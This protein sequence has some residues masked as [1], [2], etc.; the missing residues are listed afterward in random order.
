MRFLANERCELLPPV[1]PRPICCWRNLFR[2][3][4]KLLI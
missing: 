3:S 4:L 1:L 2:I